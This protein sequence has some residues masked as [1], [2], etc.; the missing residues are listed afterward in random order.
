MSNIYTLQ[1]LLDSLI[2][3][4][5]KLHLMVECK[6][7]KVP[8]CGI[9]QLYNWMGRLNV[10]RQMVT[11]SCVTFWSHDPLQATVKSMTRLQ[12][13]LEKIRKWSINQHFLDGNYS[14]MWRIASNT[15]TGQTKLWGWH[16]AA[17]QE[18]HIVVLYKTLIDWLGLLQ[19]YVIKIGLFTQC[20]GSFSFLPFRV[21]FTCQ[22]KLDKL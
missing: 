3:I 16:P 19:L 13:A 8:V 9:S 20:Y 1:W 22:C 12:S 5:A 18:R 6:Y 14:N 7:T 11:Q 15:P 4:T 21:Q 2:Y 17:I 10:I